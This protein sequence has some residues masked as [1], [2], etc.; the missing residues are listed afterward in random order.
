M[1]TSSGALPHPTPQAALCGCTG[2]WTRGGSWC[3][4]THFTKIISLPHPP[5]HSP[6]GFVRVYRLA[7]SGRQL[8]LLHRTPV[9]GI[10]GA[11]AAFKGRLVV[12]VN[13]LLRI[14]DL[15]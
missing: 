14:Y 12:G 8:E 4:Y 5:T 2:W 13:N 9:D 7:D 6:G 3:C 1:P 10:P 11:M 15:G